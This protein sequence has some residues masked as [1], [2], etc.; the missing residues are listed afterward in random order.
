M[1]VNGRIKGFQKGTLYL[2]HVQDTNYITLDSLVMNSTTD[3][4]L[5]CNL[6]QIEMLYLSLSEDIN[7][8]RIS[9][10]GS[11]GETQIN[12]TLKHF[13]YDA[14]IEGGPQQELL[15]SY[16]KNINLF[17]DQRLKFIEE[18]LNAQLKS[19]VT[20]ANEIQL[21]IDNVTRRSYLY[22]INF[23]INNKNSEVAPYIA[24]SE[25]YN[26][27]VKYL[28]TINSVLPKN[29]ADSKYGIILEDYINKI[30]SE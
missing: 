15:E 13:K 16:Y 24:L 21:Q 23:A 1:T 7:A 11:N 17:K 27:N 3:F 26:A 8:D 9:F 20:L 19:D 5:G 28:D 12:T 18:K 10:F 6:D 29:I 22:S 25:V 2:Q 30:K 4:R 14:Q